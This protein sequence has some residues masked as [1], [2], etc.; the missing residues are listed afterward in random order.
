MVTLFT[1]NPNDA[2]VNDEHGTGAAGCHPAV[3]GGALDADSKTSR[4]TDGILFGVDGTNAVLTGVAV[5]VDGGLELVPHLIAVGETRGGTH[6][7][8]DEKLLVPGDHTSAAAPV[9]GGSLAYGVCHFHE[10]FVPG[11][12]QVR[13]THGHQYKG[14]VILRQAKR[15][16]T[17]DPGY[18]GGQGINDLTLRKRDLSIFHLEN[19]IYDCNSSSRAVSFST[20]S[21]FSAPM[22]FKLDDCFTMLRPNSERM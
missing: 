19:G 12:T 4:L 22:A 10:I 8:G 1:D 5:F 11:G 15:I 16:L 18:A 9:A 20:F 14:S 21:T 6:V 2:T 7:T 13:C 17:T 3:Q